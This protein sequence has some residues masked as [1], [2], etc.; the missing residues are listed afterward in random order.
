MKYI[1]TS[2]DAT[3]RFGIIGIGYLNWSESV[4]PAGDGTGCV[5]GWVVR[6]G[7]DKHLS[8]SNSEQ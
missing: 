1:E 2:Q 7:N 8:L 4:Y 6:I 5:A 3:V